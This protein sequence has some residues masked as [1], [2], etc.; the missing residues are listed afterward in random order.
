MQVRIDRKDT[1]Q[2][3]R[4]PVLQQTHFW[5]EFKHEQGV[6]AQAFE[7]ELESGG[8]DDLLIL[9][10]H[11]G[12]GQY[13]GYVPYG[14]PLKPEDGKRG[15][16]LEELAES[17]RPHLPDSCTALRFDLKWESPWAQEETFYGEDGSWL[18][19]PSKVNQELRM[20]LSTEGWKL[21]KAHTDVLPADTLFVDISRHPETILCS[22]KAKTRYNIRLSQRKGVTVRQAD[23]SEIGTWYALYSRTCERNRINLHDIFYFE[24]LFTAEKND[25]GSADVELLFAEAEGEPLAAM[26]LVCSEKR[27]TY[28]YGASSGKNRNLMVTYALQWEAMKRAKAKG[29]TEYDFFGVAPKP[30]PAHPLYGLLRFKSGFGGEMLHRMGCWDY[31]FEQKNYEGYLA[32][33]MLSRGYHI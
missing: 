19:P 5:A 2:L 27:A 4:T 20:N 13:I 33:E 16:L 12:D 23:L 28:L 14:P 17:L 10:Q 15:Q 22:M 30:D 29:C 8:R 18:G 26:F 21:K 1:E 7:I 3:Y 6:E 24:T 25:W 9:Y 11:I 32:S 31:V